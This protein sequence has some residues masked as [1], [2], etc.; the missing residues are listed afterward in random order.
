MASLSDVT[1]ANLALGDDNGAVVQGPIDGDYRT[2]ARKL[3]EDI[4]KSRLR[5]RTVG[6]GKVAVYAGNDV[7]LCVYVLDKL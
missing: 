1:S 2:I 5:T 7:V 6:G 4:E 3:T